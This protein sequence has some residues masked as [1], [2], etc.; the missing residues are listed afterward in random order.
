MVQVE[1]R[2]R[3]IRAGEERSHGRGPEFAGE[4]CGGL[5]NDA[6]Q[7]ENH[8]ASYFLVF[9]FLFFLSF[10]RL[11]SFATF[12]PTRGNSLAAM[13]ELSRFTV[14]CSCFICCCNRTTSAG[15]TIQSRQ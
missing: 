3:K 10:A 12:S 15:S 2:G 6:R 13:S 14:F 5:V 9:F 7:N 4:C 11:A 8:L 1:R